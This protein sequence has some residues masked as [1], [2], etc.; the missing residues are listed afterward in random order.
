MAVA[1]M[2][3]RR[4]RPLVA[5]VRH[6]H[7][8]QWLLDRD[9]AEREPCA[10]CRAEVGG[11][12]TNVHTGQPLTGQPAHVVRIVAAARSARARSGT[13]RSTSGPGATTGPRSRPW[14]AVA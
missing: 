10:E 8:I 4:R 2:Q 14:S 1:P 5:E 3:T 12:C 11:T 7:S 6:E 13:S 9:D